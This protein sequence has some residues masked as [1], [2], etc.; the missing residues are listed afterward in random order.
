MAAATIDIRSIKNRG[1]KKVEIAFKTTRPVPNGLQATTEGLWIL[2]ESRD[3]YVTLVN[4]SDG[5]SI[6]EFQAV[7]GNGPSGL[8]VD[9][10]DVM[11][12]NSSDN[13]M[14]FKCDHHQGKILAKYWAP[15]AGRT[16][17]MKGDALPAQS[18]L[19]PVIRGPKGLPPA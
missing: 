8:T 19:P 3:N 13:S 10:D 18:P 15:G 5:K 16:Y 6:R 11:W 7:G 9:A 1:P 4:F 2:D 17:R 12:I 14:I